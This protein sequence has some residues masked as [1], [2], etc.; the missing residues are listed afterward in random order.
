M[1]KESSGITNAG[2]SRYEGILN[3]SEALDF[4]RIRP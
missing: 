4:K 3:S 2:A 1:S